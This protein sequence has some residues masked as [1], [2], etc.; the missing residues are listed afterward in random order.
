MLYP[1]SVTTSFCRKEK[2]LEISSTSGLASLSVRPPSRFSLDEAFEAAKIDV[3]NDS[4]HN[5]TNSAKKVG[6][7]LSQLQ[8][9]LEVRALKSYYQPSD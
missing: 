6:N 4:H 2:L 7:Y 1:Q 5:V 9:Y 8:D 3:T